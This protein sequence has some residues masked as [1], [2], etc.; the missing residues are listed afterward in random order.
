LYVSR[1]KD[2]LKET[3][4]EFSEETGENHETI[5]AASIYI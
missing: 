3:S 4:L 1:I 5:L 2:F